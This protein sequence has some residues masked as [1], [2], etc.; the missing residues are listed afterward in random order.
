MQR[1][2]LFKERTNSYLTVGGYKSLKQYRALH[3]QT[4]EVKAAGRDIGWDFRG[5][6]IE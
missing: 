5:L 2:A 1:S 6:A 3:L 4:F